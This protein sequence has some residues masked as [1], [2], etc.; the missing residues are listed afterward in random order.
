MGK[1]SS[2]VSFTSNMLCVYYPNFKAVILT[3]LHIIYVSVSY[4]VLSLQETV[5]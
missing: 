1:D 5:L 4:G 2:F 3:Q